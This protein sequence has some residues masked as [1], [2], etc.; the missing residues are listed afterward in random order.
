MSDRKIAEAVPK[1]EAQGGYAALWKGEV[2][3]NLAFGEPGPKRLAVGFPAV[4]DAQDLDR[5]AEF[6]EADAVVADAEPELRWVNVLKAFYVAFASGEETCQSVEDAECSDLINRAEFSL[7]LACPDN[8]PP[9]RQR[10]A[11]S[12]WAGVRPMRSKSS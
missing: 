2:G 12:G 4:P 1:K 3:H 5:I 8:L 10:R 9:H 7:R 11:S 6:T